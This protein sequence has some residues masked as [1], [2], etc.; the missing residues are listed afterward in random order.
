MRQRD[1]FFDNAKFILIAFVVFGHLL[2]TLVNDNE[3]IYSLYKTIYTFHMP[4]FILVSGFFAK[5]FYKKGYLATITKKL[6]L[7]YII[8]QVIYTVYYYYLYSESKLTVDFLD[9]HWSLWFLISLFCWN[10]MLLGFSKLKPAAGILL[11]L[12]IALLIGYVDTVS[13][14]LSLS[15]TFVFFPMFLIGYHLSKDHIKHLFTFKVRSSAFVIMTV[16][17][18]GFYIN[19]DINY[20]WL[21]GSKPYS[22]L[23]TTSFISMFKRLGFYGLSMIMVFSFLAFIPRGQYFFTKWGKQTLYVYLLHG[24]F[25]RFFRESEIHNYFTNPEKFVMLAGISLIITIILSSGVIASIAQPIIELKVSRTK[26]LAQYI[27]IY[28]KL[29]KKR[30]QKQSSTY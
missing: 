3:L 11:S 5:G 2:K 30:W 1:Y 7:P 29:F 22:E 13:N 18:I 26:K 15:R 25:V 20:K 12:L 16:V 4:A 27:R 24:F 9:P 17:F 21:L 14:Y 19:P 8:F 28:F 6:I 23:E 10:I